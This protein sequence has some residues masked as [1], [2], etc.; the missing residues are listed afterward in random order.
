MQVTRETQGK[1][2]WK[3]NRDMSSEYFLLPSLR[4]ALFRAVPVQHTLLLKVEKPGLETW[5]SWY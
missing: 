3:A 2:M 5:Q 1:K 4:K